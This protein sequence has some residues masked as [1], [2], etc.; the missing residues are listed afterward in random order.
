M[1]MMTIA[2]DITELRERIAR[3]RRLARWSN[4]AKASQELSQ[5][6]QELE[7]RLATLEG[8]TCQRSCR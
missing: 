5:L 2:D 6:A 7:Q 4:D 8:Q 3:Y 1:G